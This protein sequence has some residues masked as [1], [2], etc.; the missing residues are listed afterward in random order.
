MSKTEE[1]KRVRYGRLENRR[2]KNTLVTVR[3]DDTVYFGIAR[4]NVNLDTFHRKIGTYI[5]EQRALM[6]R[7]DTQ[8]FRYSEV[9]GLVLH[10]S[11]LRGSVA[12]DNVKDAVEHFRG[13]DAY[14]LEQLAPIDVEV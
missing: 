12:V 6:A 3:Q 1:T 4:C 7:D 13:V 2:P 11:G 10:E 9:G 5:A 14:C 8:A